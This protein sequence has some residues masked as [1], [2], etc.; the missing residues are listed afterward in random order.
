V[1]L[2]FFC[3]SPVFADRKEEDRARA[4]RVEE[5]YDGYKRSFPAVQDISAKEAMKRFEAGTVIFVD[6]R[7]LEEQAVSMLPGAIRSEEFLKNTARYQ[8]KLVVGYCTISYRSG[9]LA[10]KLQK[11]GITMVNLQGGI[12]AWLHAGGKVYRDG[13][14]V[15]E[16]HVYGRKWNLAPSSYQTVW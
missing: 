1:A 12:L 7:E 6:E 4:S 14:P 2:L 9:V 16:V 3:S 15:N 5:M 10:Q 8:D 11:M 13:R